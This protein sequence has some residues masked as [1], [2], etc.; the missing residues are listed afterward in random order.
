MKT[1]ALALGLAWLVSAGATATAA[2]ATVALTF[3]DLPVHGPLP[4]G[5]TRADVARSIV[6]AL[7]TAG[8]PPVY[9]FVNAKGLEEGADAAEVLKIWRAAGY[10]LG[11]HAFSHMDLHGHTVSAFEQDVLADEPTLRAAM[12]DADWHWFRYPF[13]HEGEDRAKQ[14]AV[15]A[16]LHDHG[17]RVAQVTLSFDD[18]AYNEPYARC[19]AKKDTAGLAWLEKSYMDRAARSLT[20]GQSMAQQLYGRDIPHVLLMHIGAFN[21]VMLPRLLALLHDRGFALAAL[22]AVERDPAYAIDPALP[23]P[24]TGTLLQQT[25]T[26]RHLTPPAG[27]NPFDALGALCK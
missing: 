16:F 13:L 7:Q 4:P 24:R 20:A 21:T 15:V 5:L 23:G 22:D 8:S 10:P 3:D 12:G 1:L 11:N 14:Q 25:M 9:G 26:A 6:G 17:Y 27:D 18:Y 2:E 19:A